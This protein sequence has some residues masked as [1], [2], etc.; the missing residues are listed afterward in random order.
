MSSSIG[1]AATMSR[2]HAG[3]VIRTQ[4][5][6]Y[7]PN[8]SKQPTPAPSSSERDDDYGHGGDN[9]VENPDMAIDYNA[10]VPPA[11]SNLYMLSIPGR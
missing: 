8:L 3:G 9:G 7:I 10:E 5:G 6:S 1:V 11:V 2:L 4:S